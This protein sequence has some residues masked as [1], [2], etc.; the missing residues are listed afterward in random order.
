MNLPAAEART[1]ACRWDWYA[2]MRLIQSAHP[3]A[4]RMGYSLSPTKDP[5]RLGQ[6]PF[7]H[8]PQTTIAN[9]KKLE[10]ANGSGAEAAIHSY[11]IGM[12]GPHGPLPLHLTEFA[13][14]QL[15]QGD[16]VFLSFCNT[17]SHRFISFFFRAWAEGRKELTLDR[18]GAIPV[19]HKPYAL[20]DISQHGEDLWSFFVGSLVGCGLDSNLSCDGLPVHAK[21]FHAG[22]L[23]SPNRNADGLRAIIEDFFELNAESA[24]GAKL[25][26]K[27]VN[28]RIMEFQPRSLPIPASA[29]WRMGSDGSTGFLGWSTIVGSS[30]VDYQSGF[31]IQVGPLNFSQFKDFLPSS[32]KF[33]QIHDW[34]R[35]YCGEDTDPNR[36]GGLE[37]SWDLQLVLLA[38][39]VP[40]LMLG[41][42]AQLGYTTWLCSETPEKDMDDF[43]ARPRSSEG[44]HHLQNLQKGVRSVFLQPH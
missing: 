24:E 33:H 31:R 15:R 44:A 20:N 43:V 19:E 9:L 30:V 38:S 3:E 18:L 27:K 6:P 8:A 14:R 16:P 42:T 7:F 37:S 26:A 12:F 34:V 28:T 23:L 21:L 2:L 32:E 41:E 39:A 10:N 4:P 25:P 29:Q 5:V 17:L 22:R 11:H 1:E 35:F 40:K 36:E 13:D